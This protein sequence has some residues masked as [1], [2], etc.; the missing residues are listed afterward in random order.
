MPRRLTRSTPSPARR[1]VQNGLPV[2]VS[3]SGPARS[4]PSSS[5]AASMNAFSMR[6]VVV[7]I[8]SPNVRMTTAV[9]SG[10]PIG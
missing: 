7:S 9:T 1:S 3:S 8:C 2:R 4:V 6:L 10:A 5:C